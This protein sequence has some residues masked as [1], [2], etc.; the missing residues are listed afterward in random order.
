MSDQFIFETEARTMIHRDGLEDLLDWLRTTDFYTC[1]ASTRFH[2]ACEGGLVKHSLS[3]YKWIYEIADFVTNHGHIYLDPLLPT[4]GMAIVS[5]FHDL[6]KINTYKIDYRNAKNPET[7]VWERVPYYKQEDD[8]NFG[9][10][11]AKSIF[12]INQFMK[13]TQEETIAILHHM[14]AWDKSIYSDPGKAYD[15]HPLAWVLHVADE[16]ATYIS[17]T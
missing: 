7:G 2:G 12:I 17:K 4:D 3:V 16:A 13:L 15:A 14:G 1:P 8:T 11:A 10:H 5:L 9:A 6:C